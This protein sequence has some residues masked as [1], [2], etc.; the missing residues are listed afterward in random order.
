MFLNMEIDD[1]ISKLSSS[2]PTPG[3]GSVSALGAAM[4]CGLFEMVIR[5]SYKNI[6]EDMKHYSDILNPL[7]KEAK[8]LIDKDSDAFEQVMKAYALTKTTDEEK[9]IRRNAIQESLKLAAAV[10][11][12]TAQVCIALIRLTAEIAVLSKESCVSDA[13][14]AYN[15][16]VAGFKGAID[17]VIINLASIKDDT[18]VANFKKEIEELTFWYKNS[19]D[20]IETILNQRLG[21]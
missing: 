3:G 6:E 7:K 8:E 13:A 15:F 9:E 20:S 14:C 18:F 16:A 12:K 5:I 21:A 11:F 1:F 10:P 2:S 4:A 19:K 17:N